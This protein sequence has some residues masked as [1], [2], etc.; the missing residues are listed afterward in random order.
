M[1]TFRLTS[2]HMRGAQ[3][4]QHHV[5]GHLRN[6]KVPNPGLIQEHGYFDIITRD[7]VHAVCFG[8]GIDLGLTRGAITPA[9]QQKIANTRLLTP[10]E[11][12]RNKGR[13]QWRLRFAQRFRTGA[14]QAVNF[15][16]TMARKHIVEH[17]AGSNSGPY[18]TDWERL[19]GYNSPVPWCGC[20]VNAC[21]VA[22]GLHSQGGWGIGY[23]PNI[24]AHAQSGI[25][26]WRWHGHLADP[27]PG[28]IATFGASGGEHTELVVAHG[29]PLKT[30]GGNTSDQA[31]NDAN[32]GGVWY[33]DFG[34]RAGLP[35]R[36]F[37]APNYH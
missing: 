3:Q 18:I 33:H 17:P 6:W 4:L 32:G 8:L 36:G 19:A 16:L 25:D 20:F 37:A 11:R 29:K 5:N 13:Y 23:V 1:Q 34:H 27:E 14:V 9:V 10:L 35:L 2:P 26:G 21:L 7:R 28:W 12:R 22:G 31:G 15:A 30:V 24:E